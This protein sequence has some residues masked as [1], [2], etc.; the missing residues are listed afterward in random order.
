MQA[1]DRRMATDFIK[2]LDELLDHSAGDWR[3]FIRKLGPL[4]A[5]WHLEH[6]GGTATLGFLIF[7]WE[8]IARFKK[9]GADQGLG[10]LHGI[11]AYTASQLTTFGAHYGVTDQVQAHDLASF[12]IYSGD[13]EAWHNDAHMAVGMAV[14]HDLM[15]PRTNVRRPEFWR[16]HY[17]IN[18]KFAEQL[19]HYAGGPA[20][21]HDVVVQ[22]EGG[23]GAAL[24]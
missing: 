21:P 10:G 16:L 14:H 9:S 5:R 2:A 6:N 17:F 19:H 8:L 7:H 23:A 22:L 3:T 11:H 24:I 12:E 4:H 15:N 13:V 20:T 1:Y 18:A